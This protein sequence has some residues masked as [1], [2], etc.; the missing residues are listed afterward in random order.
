MRKIVQDYNNRGADILGSIFYL[1]ADFFIV[2]PFGDGNGRVAYILMDLLLLG[3]GLRTLY[4][5]QKKGNDTVG[6]YKILD[7]VHETRDLKSL[8]EFIEKYS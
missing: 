8:Y 7:E 4:L 3:N 2:H 1:L 6:F 5:G